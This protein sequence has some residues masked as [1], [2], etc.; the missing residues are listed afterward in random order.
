M[1]KN[2]IWII[3]VVVIG[4][5]GF[6]GGMK[7]QQSK[8]TTQFGGLNGG[9]IR[10][11]QG[12]GQKQGPGYRAFQPVNGDIVSSDAQSITVKLADG[13]SKIVLFSGTTQI[14]KAATATKDDLKVGEKV[15]VFGI[16]N[17]DGSV[18]AQSIQLNP[19]IREIPSPQPTK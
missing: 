4:V 10:Q 17:P 3:L 9:Q 2:I 7:Y 18:S 13:S 12:Q 14:N 6:F 1:N 16:T 15:A 5:G 19:I 11:G 8:R